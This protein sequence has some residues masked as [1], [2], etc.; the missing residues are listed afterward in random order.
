MAL[1][2]WFKKFK[3]DSSY[4]I[5]Q[6]SFLDINTNLIKIIEIYYKY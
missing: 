4:Y 5:E 1:S 3:L 2:K 6:Q